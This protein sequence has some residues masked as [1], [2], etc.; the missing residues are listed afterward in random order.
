MIYLKLLHTVLMRVLYI[1]M[2]ISNQTYKKKRAIWI[3]KIFDPALS[4]K[5][6][7]FFVIVA[8][9]KPNR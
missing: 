4:V 7:I 1:S 6:L 2:I 8:S 9:K 5:G 3:I